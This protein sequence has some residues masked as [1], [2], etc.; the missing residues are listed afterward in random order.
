MKRSSKLTCAIFLLAALPGLA[1]AQDSIGVH[2][3][4]LKQAIA[5]AEKNNVQVKNALL[6]YQIQQQ[7]NKEITAAA[8]PSINGS[9]STTYNAKLPVSL[10]PAEFF[11]GTAGTFQ[12]IAFGTKWNASYGVEL[13]QLLFDGQVFVGLQAKASS[14]EFRTKTMEITKEAVRANI[15]KIYYQLVVSRKQME[16]LDANISRL[17]KLQHDTRE[18]YKNGFAE[19]LDVDKLTVALANLNSEKTRTENLI[20]NGYLGLKVLMGMPVAEKLVLTDTISDS[21]IKETA[22]DPGS[23]KFSDRLDYQ[24]L[25]VGIKLRE[26]NIRRYKL[27]K[28]P[29]VS[30][31]AYY[32]KNAQRNKFDFFS[33][34]WFDISAIS[35]RIN[36]PIFSGGAANARIQKA[37]YE[38]NQDMNNRTAM[39]LNINYEIEQARN[40]FHTAITNMDYQR[41]NMELAESVYQQT[42]KKYEMGLGSQTEI[43]A[44]QT[45]LKAAQTNYI[46]A[47]YDAIIAKVDFQKATG[48]L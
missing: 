24:A 7:T 47:L 19:K 11:G 8:F 34:E 37:R 2:E 4:S 20:G 36:I 32:N 16:L 31:N 35:M 5:Y 13:N 40:N 15:T 41:R 9:L 45:D 28:L 10:V 30:L 23:F 46:T 44:A 21:Q 14:L 39:E 42:K 12:K 26:Y 3:F 25:S 33:G 17:E 38:L 1:A 18:I 29:T 43:T 6:D 22:L 48:K 27:S